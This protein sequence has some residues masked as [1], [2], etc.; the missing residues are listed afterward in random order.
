MWIYYWCALTVLIVVTVHS[1]YVNTYHN[2]LILIA[3]IDKIRMKGETFGRILK[4]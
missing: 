2:V 3:K 4:P 1:T